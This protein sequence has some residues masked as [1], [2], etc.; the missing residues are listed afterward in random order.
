MS[1]KTKANLDDKVTWA[2]VDGYWCLR[3]PSS[4]VVNGAVVQVQKKDG[5]TSDETVERVFQT[6]NGISFAEPVKKPREKKSYSSSGYKKSKSSSYSKYPRT[7]CSC[8][9]RDGIIQDSDCWTC[10]HD[11]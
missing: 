5:S 3:G 9:S 2:N 11:A 7:G 4:V 1:T 6:T 8:G 10:K